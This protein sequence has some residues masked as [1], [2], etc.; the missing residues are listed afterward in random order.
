M[1]LVATKAET[2]RP[3]TAH[4]IAPVQEGDDP[5]CRSR[6]ARQRGEGGLLPSAVFYFTSA[7]PGGVSWFRPTA[8]VLHG[9][10]RTTHG[11]N[12]HVGSLLHPGPRAL[13]DGPEDFVHGVRTQGSLPKLSQCQRRSRCPQ[14]HGFQRLLRVLASAPTSQSVL[15]SPRMYRGRARPRVPPCPRPRFQSRP[16]CWM[17][18]CLVRAAIRADVRAGAQA[19]P[20]PLRPS[21]LC[22]STR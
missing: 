19:P 4:G 22:L 10:V 9:P 11:I 20:P 21:H 15:A 2:L 8:W 12:Q 14:P 17:R 7:L 16:P 3:H 18:W 6:T 5:R 1:A 13:S